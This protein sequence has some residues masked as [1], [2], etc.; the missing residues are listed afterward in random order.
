MTVWSKSKKVALVRLNVKK[1]LYIQVLMLV[2]SL[3]ILLLLGIDQLTVNSVCI[4]A[5]INIVPSAYFTYYAFRYAGA[6]SAALVARSF[7]RG[8]AV[9]FILTVMMFA[10]V[11]IWIKPL[12]VMA[13]FIAYIATVI[14]SWLVATKLTH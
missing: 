12:N 9:K 6:Q 4:G 8:E 5:L 1:L 11:F 2:V 10:G 14:V 13:L 3:I 7:Y